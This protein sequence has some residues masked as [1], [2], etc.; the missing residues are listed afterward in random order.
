M[1]SIVKYTITLRPLL[2]CCLMLSAQLLHGQQ[3]LS[4]SGLV[5]DSD[6]AALPGVTIII[7]GT[8]H[9]TISNAEGRYSLSDVP[10]GATLDFSFVGMK[11]THLEVKSSTVNAVME[12]DF[13]GVDEV[14][15]VGYGTQQKKDLT[16][17]VSTINAGTLEQIPASNALQAL[18]GRL[19]GVNIVSQDGRPGAS[20]S[21]RIRGGGSISQ[22]NN[23]LLIVDG[24]PVDD[25]NS[26]PVEQIESVSVL[27]DAASTAI[28]GA[29]GANGVILVTTKSPK[30]GELTIS[31]NGYMQVKTP[32]K[33]PKTLSGQEYI[34][35]TWSYAAALGNSYRA[36]VEKYF[37]LGDSQGNHYHDYANVA[38][39][40]HT[41]D[42]LRTAI[43]QNHNFTVSGG[44]KDTKAY[45]NIS[46]LNDDGIQIQSGYRQE[47]ATFK[48]QQQLADKFR[49]NAE[50]FVYRRLAENEIEEI[51]YKGS[52]ASSAY[53]FHPIDNP[54]GDASDISA[55][56]EGSSNVDNSYCPVDLIKNKKVYLE[57][58]YMR[59]FIG[60]TYNPFRD[61]E[62]YT[63]ATLSDSH[64]KEYDYNNGL[65]DQK[66]IIIDN[67][68]GSGFRWVTTLNIKKDLNANNRFSLLFGNELRGSEL[69]T[70]TVKGLGFPN[71]FN[72][73]NAVGLVQNATTNSV[74]NN[75]AVPSRICS[76]FARGNYTLQ[77]K[78][79]F[80]ATF[81]ADASSKF[82]PN[83][84]WGYFP[85]AAFG[86][87]M[88][89]EDFLKSA[90]WL[91]NL[92]LRISWGYAGSDNIDP[93]LWR[94][95]WIS[96]DAIDIGYE[97]DGTRYPILSPKGQKEN[98]DLKW[99]T[100]LSRNL[101][102]DYAFWGNRVYGS[103][104]SYW[105][106]TKDLLMAVD[107]DATTGYSTQYQNFGQTSNKGFES[108]LSVDI[109][110]QR[111]FNLSANFIYNYNYNKVDK[112]NDNYEYI[113]STSW[114][115]HTSMPLYDYV[116]QAGQP[117]GLARG[118]QTD[119]IYSVDDFNYVNGQYVLKSG[120]ADFKDIGGNHPHPFNT[121]SGQNAYPGA[122]KYVNADKNTAIDAN[123]YRTFEMQARHTGSV[124]LTANYRNWDASALFNWVYGGQIFNAYSMMSLYGNKDRYLGAN[125]LALVND[126]F[127]A[128]Q[129]NDAG[130]LYAV[131]NPEELAELN[132]N[133][134]Y[135][136]PYYERGTAYDT[137]MEDGSYLRLAN[138][139]VGYSL[140]K[141]WLNRMHINRMRLYLSGTNLF[142]LT[143]YTGLDPE[144]DTR[145]G[146]EGL[147]QTNL[148]Y[149]A[150]PRARTFTFG[151]NLSL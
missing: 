34:L 54:L 40:D 26:I 59:A 132:K 137:F 48:L 66:S 33:M 105:N 52:V 35:H 56:A 94:E 135:G 102:V 106:I 143:K 71:S 57:R 99:E 119:G 127:K 151:M 82:A 76:F 136:L 50:A 24:F 42:I 37:G 100:T 84:Q 98:P 109:I 38:S 36:G 86:W 72:F 144:V 83:H 19:A 49:L 2:I 73:D 29:S 96:V 95:S 150:Y 89:E 87:R 31:Y 43:T 17:A 91:D 30:E 58:Q 55:F 45:A 121:P 5:A 97:V 20:M 112:L 122:I 41:E 129:V 9:G 125:R 75:E 63:E 81:R 134:K 80:T 1:R 139:T 113:Y 68:D 74:T 141:P 92:K 16:G 124:N 22:S 6:G 46:Y 8:M 146:A 123:D 108:Q 104:E 140:P 7:K 18:Q 62:L 21:I 53:M 60:L 130:E 90:S 117:I 142:C 13:I 107:I 147:P 64:E 23:P 115:A 32:A 103:L 27:K 131:S 10:L 116:V 111:E 25:F 12:I 85:S 44:T 128:Y 145:Q 61:V 149:G 126:A 120:V 118:Y 110:R 78:Y 70:T 138:L 67:A 4:V 51:A 28:Y 3:K 47:S 15:S 148:D 133:A 93:S 88:S 14:V 114:A 79:L 69:T 65:T 101:G 39:H 11:S 77:D